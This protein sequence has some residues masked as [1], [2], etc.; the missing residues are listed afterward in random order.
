MIYKIFILFEWICFK[1]YISYVYDDHMIWLQ[2]VGYLF[3]LVASISSSV[4]M[5]FQKLAQHEIYYH[6][7]RTRKHKR[8]MPLKTTVFFRP[9][10]AIAIFLSIAASTLDFLALTWLPPS[11]VGVFG[12]MSIIINLLVTRVILFER[13]TK[14]E[15]SAIAYVI[16]G[17]LLAISVTPDHDSGMP[18]P[19]LLDR[20]IS[21]AYII[22]NWI[23]FVIFSHM[24][25]NLNLPE[26]IQRF[27]YP[28]I[29]GALGSQNVCMG[30][31]IAYA[32]STIN[33]HGLTVRIDNFCATILLC[34]ASV[35][36]HIIWLNKGLEKY[37]AYFCII[38]Y[39][40]AWFM[41]TTISGIVVYND[42]GVL[43]S[44]EQLIFVTGLLTA[45]YGVKKISVIHKENKND[46]IETKEEY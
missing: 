3:L 44:M 43:T 23:I 38:I 34:L 22:G 14:E 17:C 10:F 39:Q 20:P 33:D 21:Y 30:K 4:S 12:S 27:G 19:Q 41:F 35:I 36:I 9:L 18:I 46:N 45:V 15:W 25:E 32:V 13:P 2:L 28:F 26:A 8:S 1:S 5:N 37:D 6:D 16:L 7:P 40:T 31:Y 24:L 29:A 42:M 11:T